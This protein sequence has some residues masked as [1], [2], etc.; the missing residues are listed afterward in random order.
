[1]YVDDPADALRVLDLADLQIDE[2]PGNGR[3]YPEPDLFIAGVFRM[4]YVSTGHGRYSTDSRCE[5]PGVSG[6]VPVCQRLVT[7]QAA[8]RLLGIPGDQH[9]SGSNQRWFDSR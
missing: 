9:D 2:A 6:A 7:E 5:Q 1:M 3:A 4:I 8:N